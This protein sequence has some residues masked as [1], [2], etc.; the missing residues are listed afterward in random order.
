MIGLILAILVFGG[1]AALFLGMRASAVKEKAAAAERARLAAQAAVA[2][3]L[4]AIA[5]ADS[6]RMAAAADSAAA[7]TAKPTKGGK[8]SAVA[9]AQPTAKPTATKPSA[10]ASKPAAGGGA[11]A[12]APAPAPA[13]PAEK[14][15]FGLDVGTFLVEERA[16]SELQ[17]LAAAT[18]LTGKVVTKSED[19]SDVYHVVLGSFPTRAAAERKAGT[20]VAEGKVNQAKPISLAS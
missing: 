3:S 2:E 4:A 20:L 1:G 16:N 6:M 19:G 17:K 8:P 7:A 11:T 12:A 5:Q 13:K 10:A 9:K 18:G 14:G 15:P